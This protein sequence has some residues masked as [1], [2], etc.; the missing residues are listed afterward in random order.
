VRPYCIWG[1]RGPALRRLNTRSGLAPDE[2]NLAISDSLLGTLSFCWAGLIKR[3]IC[4]RLRGAANARLW[5]PIF[6]WPG[7]TAGN[8][9]SKR[10]DLRLQSRYG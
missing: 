2:P 4:C 1:N 7:L 9:I 8:G 5:E 10:P 6:I 3:L